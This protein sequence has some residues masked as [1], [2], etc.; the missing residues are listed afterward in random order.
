MDWLLQMYIKFNTGHNKFIYFM[1]PILALL[2]FTFS[3]LF[4]KL[5]FKVLWQKKGRLLID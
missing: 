3:R 5:V 4:L 2:P 1:L